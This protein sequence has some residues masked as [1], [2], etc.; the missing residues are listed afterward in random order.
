MNEEMK[1]VHVRRIKIRKDDCLVSRFAVCVDECTP[2]KQQQYSSCC[3]CFVRDGWWFC[4]FVCKKKPVGNTGSGMQLGGFEDDRKVPSRL[5]AEPRGFELRTIT[6]H[7][8]GLSGFLRLFLRL[9][10]L[11]SAGCSPV[12]SCA[13]IWVLRLLL[14]AKT[15]TF[16]AL[17]T[18]RL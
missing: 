18:C 14:N 4:V 13:E 2:G 12:F 17:F 3:V 16:V 7:R 5:H 15:N 10:C 6:M 11:G 9:L 8:Y 1:Q